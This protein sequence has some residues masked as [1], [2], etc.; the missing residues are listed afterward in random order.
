VSWDFYVGKA[1]FQFSVRAETKFA[2]APRPTFPQFSTV[3]WNLHRC[4]I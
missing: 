1:R 3:I 2:L 4:P